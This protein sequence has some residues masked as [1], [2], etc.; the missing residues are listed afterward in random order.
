MGRPRKTL[1][2]KESSSTGI[3]VFAEVSEN[4][5]KACEELDLAMIWVGEWIIVQVI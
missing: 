2:K 3:E 5:T 4:L 1:P